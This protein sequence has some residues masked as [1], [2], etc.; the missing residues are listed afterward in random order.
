MIHMA[1][2]SSSVIYDEIFRD[3][4]RGPDYIEIYW[5]Q[6]WLSAMT[7]RHTGQCAP[8]RFVIGETAPRNIRLFAST[9][10]NLIVCSLQAG[11]KSLIWSEWFCLWLWAERRKEKKIT[12]CLESRFPNFFFYTF[13]TE[14]FQTKT[15]WRK[16]TNEA[17]LCGPHSHF[18][19][20]QA[21]MTL[22]AYLGA[23]LL[24]NH[25]QISPFHKKEGLNL[26]VLKQISEPPLKAF[27]SIQASK[28]H[29]DSPI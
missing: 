7:W 22:Q 1:S 13:I 19:Q 28:K 25:L 12:D 26:F 14:Q 11:N 20:R 29:Q 2:T 18:S 21:A 10:K 17:V 4:G 24:D 5:V 9:M 6:P 3:T 16:Q 8:F 27:H 23:T 15:G